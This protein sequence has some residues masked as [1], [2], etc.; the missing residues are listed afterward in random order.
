MKDQTSKSLFTCQT[1]QTTKQ[2]RLEQRCQFVFIKQF[3]DPD[4][5]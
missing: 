5:E 4:Q 1:T 3:P 2:L